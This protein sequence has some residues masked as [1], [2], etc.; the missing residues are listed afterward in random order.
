M[1]RSCCKAKKE[2]EI[3]LKLGEDQRAAAAQKQLDNISTWP[4]TGCTAKQVDD[5]WRYELKQ[6]SYTTIEACLPLQ[7]SCSS[8]PAVLVGQFGSIFRV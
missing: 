3:A 1:P 4:K 5:K 8:V 6:V 7:G 2:H